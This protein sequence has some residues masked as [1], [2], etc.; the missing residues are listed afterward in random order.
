MSKVNQGK[1][2]ALM[3]SS[4]RQPQALHAQR[5][6]QVTAG[7]EAEGKSPQRSSSWER[8]QDQQDCKTQTSGTTEQLGKI[9][10]SAE[11]MLRGSLGWMLNPDIVFFTEKPCF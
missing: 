11:T 1:P 4:E 3:R 10:Y 6:S 5:T 7:S 8:H 2:L 9:A